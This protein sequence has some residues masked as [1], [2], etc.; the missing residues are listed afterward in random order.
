VPAS[1]KQTAPRQGKTR[2][3]FEE[4]A[5]LKPVPCLRG[6]G[7]PKRQ[8]LGKVI[9][10][11]AIRGLVRSTD[12]FQWKDRGRRRR[13]KN[14]LSMVCS[15]VLCGRFVDGDMPQFCDFCLFR[16][17]SAAQIVSLLPVV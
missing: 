4:D 14:V 3:R 11:A 5:F 17:Q 12:G 16:N 15:L 6:T 2:R 10:I 13:E 8:L 7:N 9:R 1:S